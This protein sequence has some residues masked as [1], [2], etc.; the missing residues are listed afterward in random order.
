LTPTQQ[1]EQREQRY[2]P[3]FPV[4]AKPAPWNDFLSD[5][6]GQDMIEYVLVAALLGLVSITAVNGLGAKISS[7]YTS[8]SSNLTSN[9]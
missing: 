8:L 4:V 1:P 3:K 2:L 6:S 5:D 9:T 7:A